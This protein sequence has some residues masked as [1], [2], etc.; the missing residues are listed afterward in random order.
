M[1]SGMMF[2]FHVRNT[3][4]KKYGLPYVAK[5]HAKAFK[6]YKENEERLRAKAYRRILPIVKR[7]WK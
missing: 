1:A 6:K 4:V 3:N 5:T 2:Q 7:L